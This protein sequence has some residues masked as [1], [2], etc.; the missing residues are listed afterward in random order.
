MQLR[1]VCFALN[2][3]TV[4]C[5]TTDRKYQ[6]LVTLHVPLNHL[7]RKIRYN[8]KINGRD[9][10]NR[11]LMRFSHDMC[12]RTVELSKAD[13]FYSSAGIF[14]QLKMN[15]L[16]PADCR[17]F[18]RLLYVCRV[19]IRLLQVCRVFIRLLYRDPSLMP[20]VTFT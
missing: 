18:I 6:A 13:R 19:F 12:D 15:S 17:V 11:F 3:Y 2:S 7:S 1:A 20:E 16:L 9:V 14:P 4:A 10:R 5:C 8:I